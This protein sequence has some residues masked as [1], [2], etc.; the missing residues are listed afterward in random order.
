MTGTGARK[1]AFNLYGQESGLGNQY[2]SQ[3]LGV[4]STLAPALT[5]E[6]VN[7]QGF[8]PTTKGQMTTAAE[9]TAGGSNAGAAGSAGLRAARTRNIGSGQ[10]ATAD[11]SRG[12]SERLS[13]TNAG[14]QSEDAQL[15]AKQS[16][17][18]L[19]GLGALYGT[20]VNAGNNALGLANQ[21]TQIA[22]QQ[23]PGYWQ[24][25]GQNFGT[26]VL[27]GAEAATGLF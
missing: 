25:F 27:N 14:I 12:A 19:S 4:N 11:A 5:A 7:P 1:D 3:A 13:Q 26:D 2:A 10:A 24:Q 16:Q 15:K 17:A 21:A 6:A 22:G 8:N 20:D 23:K 18:G 9:Q